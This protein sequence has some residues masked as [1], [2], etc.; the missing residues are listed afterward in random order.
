VLRD[1]RLYHVRWTRHTKDSGTRFMLPDGHRM[2]FAR[3]QVWVIYGLGPG[4]TG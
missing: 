1:G 4:S 3:G 2:P